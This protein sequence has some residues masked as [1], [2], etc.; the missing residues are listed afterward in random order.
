MPMKITLY[1]LQLFL[2]WP[3]FNI[4]KDGMQLLQQKFLFNLET[5]FFRSSWSTLFV[6]IRSCRMHLGKRWWRGQLLI[7]SNS[8]LLHGCITSRSTLNRLQVY[9]Q[10]K[11]KERGEQKRQKQVQLKSERGALCQ[12]C[13]LDIL[14][15]IFAQTFFARSKIK[16]NWKYVV[17]TIGFL[18]NL[19][20]TCF[21]VKL[22]GIWGISEYFPFVNRLPR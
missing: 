12:E 2:I 16:E 8:C 21:Q 18:M 1:K 7:R 22:K 11:Q 6:E 4:S 3:C 14:R 19:N 17:S 13:S 9:C 15:T 5:F 20:S 10:L